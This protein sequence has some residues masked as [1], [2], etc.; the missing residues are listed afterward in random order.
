MEMCRQAVLNEHPCSISPVESGA[1]ACL[2][3][4]LEMLK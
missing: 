2:V 4:L 3:F 1:R